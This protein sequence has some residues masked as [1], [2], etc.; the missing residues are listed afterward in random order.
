MVRQK[1]VSEFDFILFGGSPLRH[2][3]RKA[4]I[5]NLMTVLINNREMSRL[6][7]ESQF[8]SKMHNEYKIIMDDYSENSE[9]DQLKGIY[10]TKMYIP[11]WLEPIS[12]LQEINIAFHHNKKLS[13][14]QGKSLLNSLIMLSD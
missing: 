12:L 6:L 13:K 10:L 8:I 1:V 11:F 4:A 9:K 3:F 7:I 14:I 5:L 2:L